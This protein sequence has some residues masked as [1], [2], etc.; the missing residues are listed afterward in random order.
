MNR[1]PYRRLPSDFF[2]GA[3]PLGKDKCRSSFFEGGDETGLY[4]GEYIMHIGL[5]PRAA[6]VHTERMGFRDLPKNREVRGAQTLVLCV[7]SGAVV[8]WMLD[9]N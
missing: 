4:A 3:P 5:V 2:Y 6:L 9:I 1:D 7:S 8:Q